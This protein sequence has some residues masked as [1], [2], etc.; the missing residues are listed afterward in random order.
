MSSALLVELI[1]R[2]I[3]LLLNVSNLFQK[4]I[5]IAVV[6]MGWENGPK[7]FTEPLKLYRQER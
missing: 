5:C 4:M 7:S 6:G 3:Q 1:S 2:C